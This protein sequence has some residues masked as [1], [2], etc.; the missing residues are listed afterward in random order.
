[1]RIKTSPYLVLF[2][3]AFFLLEGCKKAVVD[4]S[5]PAGLRFTWTY[6]GTNF[7]VKESLASVYS[8]GPYLVVAGTDRDSLRINRRVSFTLTSFDVANYIVGSGSNNF[9]YVDD[10]GNELFGKSGNVAIT[11]SSNNLLSGNFSCT[12]IGPSNNTDLITG[13][14]SNVPIKQ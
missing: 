6:R 7:S 8:L 4:S 13:S 11:S 1:V 10:A 12:L 14:F 3:V 2:V 5:Q 9:D